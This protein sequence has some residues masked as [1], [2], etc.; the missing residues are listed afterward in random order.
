MVESPHYRRQRRVALESLDLRSIDAPIVDLIADFATLSHCFTLQSCY[1]H[2]LCSPVQA[3]NTFEPVPAGHGGPV[4]YRIAYIALCIANDPS[5]RSLLK[6]LRRVPAI[7]PDYVQFGSADWFWKRWP[8]SYALQVEPMRYK[9]RDEAVLQVA[10]AL[11]VQGTRDVFFR[12]LRSLVTRQ[13]GERRAGC[14]G[15]EDG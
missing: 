8:N 3:P 15:D 12:E 11:H 9:R 4:R 13:L 1:G 7:D 6:S 2:F 5:G 10:E 14:A